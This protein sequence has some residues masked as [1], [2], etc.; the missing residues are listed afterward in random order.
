[1]G[2][3]WYDDGKLLHK[4]NTFS[5]FAAC[6]R[7]LVETGWTTPTGSSPRAARPAGC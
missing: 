5:D 7:H 6:A 4:R 3:R 2:R 1:M